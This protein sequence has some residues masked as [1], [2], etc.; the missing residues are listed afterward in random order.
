V[1]GC[2]LGGGGGATSGVAAVGEALGASVPAGVPG[3]AEWVATLPKAA[4]PNRVADRA[5]PI[6]INQTL[7]V[8]TM[9]PSPRQTGPERNERV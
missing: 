5:Q 8:P 7:P 3:T 1:D 9:A 6:A 4:A 2:R